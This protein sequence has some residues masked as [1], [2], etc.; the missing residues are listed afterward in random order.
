MGLLGFTFVAMIYVRV[1]IWDRSHSCL[2]RR[3]FPVGTQYGMTA[4]VAHEVLI[5]ALAGVEKP[6]IVDM[7]GNTHRVPRR[8]LV[9]ILVWESRSAEAG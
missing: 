9:E 8:R 2:L 6:T 5:T 4:K 7:A 3:T 1:G